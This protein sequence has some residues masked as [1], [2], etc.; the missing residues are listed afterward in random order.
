MILILGIIA[1]LQTSA[2]GHFAISYLDNVLNEQIGQ[3]AMRVAMAIAA[4]PDVI[5]AVAE[6]NTTF[7]QPLSHKLAQAAEAR[8]VVFGDAEG[9]RL[10]HPLPER[11]GR[12]MADDEGDTNAPALRHGRAYVSEALGS[13]GWSVRGKAPI[14]SHDGRT[15]I[16]IVSVGYL[17]DTVEVIVSHHTGSMLVAIVAA[18]LFSVGTAI[19]FANHFRKAIFN[20]EPEQ[21]ARMFQERNATLETVREGIVAINQT[22][23]ITT[24]N[25]AAIKTLEL[26]DD[27]TYIGRH[28]TEVLPDTGMQE[29]LD[30]GQPH[31]DHDIWLHD[32]N[33]IVNRIPLLQDGEV[34]GVVSSFRLKNEL[35]LVSRKLTRIK[36]YAE[37][38]RS[39][40]HEYNNKLHTIAGLIQID[41]KEEAL[42]VIGQETVSH[43][44]FIQQLMQVTSDSVLAGCLLGKYNRAKELGLE[45]AIDENSQMSDLPD[46]LPRE[47]LV[48][49]LGNLIDN[50]L[51][52]TLNHYGPGGTVTL[53][54]SDY[55]KELIFEVNDQGAGLTPEEA[56]KIFTRGYTTKPQ[57][58]HGIGLDLVRS[59][60]DH[61]GGLITVEPGEPSGSDAPEPYSGSRFTVYLPKQAWRE[62]AQHQQKDTQ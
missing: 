27:R 46:P 53:G 49:I 41:A 26:P 50:A 33:L 10:A 47:Q 3:Q 14:F 13:V 45:L 44:A 8:F 12:P 4:T 62:L 1:I 25:H 2:L 52:A 54:F 6:K 34:T 17:L 11:V 61:L 22:G 21:I 20:L 37:T 24:F 58:G 38:L 5:D 40:A 15:V 59:Q 9:I 39:Q 60:V 23:H 55:G 35:D 7:L 56:E 30:Q 51:E 29:V 31:F 48:S 43:Q 32:H 19:L 57:D 16:G 42:A 36:Q 28:I 18:F